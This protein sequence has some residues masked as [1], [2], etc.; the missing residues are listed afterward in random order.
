MHER[1]GARPWVARTELAY[2]DMLLAR[3][4]RGDRA[5]ARELLAD[6]ARTAETLGMPVVAGRARELLAV[7]GA[8]AARR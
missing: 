2:A 3:R 8:V 6:A 4:A 1:M 5:R 7:V